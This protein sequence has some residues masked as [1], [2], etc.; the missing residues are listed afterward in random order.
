MEDI[1]G[2]PKSFFPH[3]KRL[4]VFVYWHED[5]PNWDPYDDEDTDSSTSEDEVPRQSST[6]A[7]HLATSCPSLQRF[8]FASEDD[9]AG[10]T[11]SN[12][13]RKPLQW[14]KEADD[15]TMVAAWTW[16]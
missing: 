1:T 11:W 16:A 14:R 13:V 6:F 10:F 8:I 12:G 5:N 7:N 9:D 15:Y 3:L 4:R 2:L